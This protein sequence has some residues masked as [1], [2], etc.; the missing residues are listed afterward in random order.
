MPTTSRDGLYFG[1]S[2]YL[3]VALIWCVVLGGCALGDNFTPS[4]PFARVAPCTQ[5]EA[6]LLPTSAELVVPSLV[7]APL[8]VRIVVDSS[9]DPFMGASVA[10]PG[11]RMVWN[12]WIYRWYD[13]DHLGAIGRVPDVVGDPRGGT[14]QWYEPL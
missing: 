3:W 8:G 13:G 5:F 2:A 6:D 14:C 11:G 12:V 4:E 7:A 1:I 9:F 10:V